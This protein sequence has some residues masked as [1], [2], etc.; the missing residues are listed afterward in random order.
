MGYVEETLTDG[1]NVIYT[2]KFHWTHTFAAYLWLVVF[3]VAVIGIIMFLVLMIMKWTTEIA[4]TNKRMLYKRGWIAR[5]VDE[6]NI[7]R[8]EGCNV[9]QGI[10][11]RMF[12]YGKLVVRGTGIGELE[13][14]N[15]D[16]PLALRRAIDT[17]KNAA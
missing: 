15:I 3:G 10:F 12:G 8:I 17:A 4:I 5:K 7:D 1:E 11:G 6:V 14:P 2:A 16:E 13:L 9:N